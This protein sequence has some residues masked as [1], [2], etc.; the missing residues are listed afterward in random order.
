MFRCSNYNQSY[1]LT[2]SHEN[3]PSAAVEAHKSSSLW[4]YVRLSNEY[5]RSVLFF[6]FCFL[7]KVMAGRN[8]DRSDVFRDHKSRDEDYSH[9]GGRAS[10]DTRDRHQLPRDAEKRGSA[11][12]RRVKQSRQRGATT[13]ADRETPAQRD[14]Y[15]EGPSRMYHLR[16]LS[17]N[18]EGVNPI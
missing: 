14:H 15:R 2:A 12:D 10:P 6:L 8:H 18:N 1:E 11:G 17:P 16:S 7:A 4:F 5:P 13:A 3:K 9:R